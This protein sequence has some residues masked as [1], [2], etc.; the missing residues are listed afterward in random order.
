MAIITK[1]NFKNVLRALGFIE[2]GDIFEK[3]FTAF[4]SSLSVN[5]AT[6]RLIYPE[7]IKGRDRTTILSNLKILLCLSV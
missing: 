7:E 4:N 5:F 6:E 1:T 2:S 3:K